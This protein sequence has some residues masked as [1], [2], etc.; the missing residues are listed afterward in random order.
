[1]PACFVE[2]HA[3]EAAVD[4]HGHGARRTMLRAQHGQRRLRRAARRGLHIDAFAEKFESALR[5][6]AD[7]ARLVFAIFAGHGVDGHAGIH[8]LVRHHQPFAVGDDHVGLAVHHLRAHLR[9]ERAYALG[10][11]IRLVQQ[12]GLRAA[13]HVHGHFA[14]RVYVRGHAAHERNRPLRALLRANGVRRR[15]RRRAK[16]GLRSVV[17]IYIGAFQLPVY[18]HARAVLAPGHAILNLAIDQVHVG[19]ARV[20]PKNLGKIAAR[21]QRYAQRPF[22]CHF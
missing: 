9:D 20:F 8:A 18:P 15:A 5:A 6:R 17:R 1:M 12:L 2:D 13:R 16:P 4:D 7:K 19:F 21:R 3:A 14:N 22:Q 11:G 10:R